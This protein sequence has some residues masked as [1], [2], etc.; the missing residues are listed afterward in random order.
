MGKY[1]ILNGEWPMTTKLYQQAK[2]FL[3][4]FTL[5]FDKLKIDL[6]ELMR[7]NFSLHNCNK[8]MNII[9]E[10]SKLFGKSGGVSK[11]EISFNKTRIE[12]L[13]ELKIDDTAVNHL[14]QV[15]Q[16]YNSYNENAK[17]SIYQQNLYE[18]IKKYKEIGAEWAFS[19]MGSYKTIKYEI[20]GTIF[21][22]CEHIF[23]EEYS[24]F[25]KSK[26]FP[27][28]SKSIILIFTILFNTLYEKLRKIDVKINY[29]RENHT[30]PIEFDA[31][32]ESII[33]LA[34]IKEKYFPNDEYFGKYLVLSN[35]IPDSFNSTQGAKKIFDNYEQIYNLYAQNLGLEYQDVHEYVVKNRQ[36]IIDLLTQRYNQMQKIC[37]NESEFLAQR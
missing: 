5:D 22:E 19:H 20:L 23:Q 32:Y 4:D 36:L 15:E 37:E 2:N 28:D 26:K 14:Q 30:F 35:I 1:Y 29:V 17:H 8:K 31:R 9:F 33:Q 21:H 11:R 12:M 7:V 3:D 16:F 27:S 24:S 13:Q 10:E 18:F 25:L 34:T 6:E